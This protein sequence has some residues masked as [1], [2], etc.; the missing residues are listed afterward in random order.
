MEVAAPLKILDAQLEAN[1]LLDNIENLSHDENESR[2][3]LWIN[4]FD[5]NEPFRKP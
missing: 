2:S 3:Y 4:I 1:R 5:D